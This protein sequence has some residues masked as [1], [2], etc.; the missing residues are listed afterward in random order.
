MN[1]IRKGR[2]KGVE[3]ADVPGQVSCIHEIF[4]VAA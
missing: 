4:G 2:V 3:K 1:Q